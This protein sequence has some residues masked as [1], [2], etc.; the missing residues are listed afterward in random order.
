MPTM[1]IARPVQVAAPAQQSFEEAAAQALGELQRACA[2][3]LAAVPGG[4][5]RAVDLEKGLK[6]DK[7]LAW[8]VFKIA[9]AKHSID[10]ALNVPP[11]TAV[12]RLAAA[13]ARKRMSGPIVQRVV[14][15]FE[16]FEA[17]VAHHAGDRETF[18]SMVG[19]VVGDVGQTMLEK[20][21][22]AQYR[23]C[24]HLWGVQSDAGVRCAVFHPKEDAPEKLDVAVIDGYR[25]LHQLRLDAHLAIQVGAF[26]RGT[27]E[28]TFGQAPVLLEE[29]SDPISAGHWVPQPA[30]HAQL[31]LSELGRGTAVSFFT[32]QVLRPAPVD[33]RLDLDNTVCIAMPEP[34]IVIDL[35]VPTGFSD[36][37][38][39]NVTV[40]GARY[41]YPHWEFDPSL[42]LPH[43]EHVTTVR[44]VGSPPEIPEVP[45]Y[46]DAVSHVLRTLGW[47]STRFDAYRCRVAY[48]FFH[49]Q[50]RLNVNPA[51]GTA[52]LASADKTA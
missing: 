9:R 34:L 39:A 26:E 8:Q 37:A 40:Y 25:N 49:T 38:S 5:H 1:S 41:K 11:R 16:A 13:A 6:L 29:F 23:A 42:V 47:D 27:D 28:A 46:T 4:V 51:G 15:A 50:I 19:S 14:Q 21:R 30:G 17:F 18:S 7:K 45:Q 22:V 44:G 20:G 33:P 2:A 35:L 36:P 10:E 52:R 48:P 32:Q 43:R 31:E 3:L 24:S 12:R